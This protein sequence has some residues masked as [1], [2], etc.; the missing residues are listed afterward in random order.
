MN[1][2]EK[3][4]TPLQESLIILVSLGNQLKKALASMVFGDRINDEELKFTLSNHIHILLCSFLDEWKVLVSMGRDETIRNTLKITSP[5]LKRIQRWEGLEQVRNK[6]LAHG[7]R[8][9]NRVTVWP[10]LSVIQS[11]FTSLLSGQSS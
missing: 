6:L 8:H 3:M 5:A 10:R 7:Q 11:S 4:L 1:G 2:N 9:K